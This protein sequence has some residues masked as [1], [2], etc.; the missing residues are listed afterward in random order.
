MA[1]GV[2]P[3]AADD[4]PHLRHART[5]QGLGGLVARQRLLVVEQTPQF[6]SMGRSFLQCFVHIPIKCSHS[7]DGGELFYI[8]TTTVMGLNERG[9]SLL[10]ECRGRLGLE[11]GLHGASFIHVG[12]RIGI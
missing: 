10:W 3:S 2:V 6:K 4:D 1:P 7:C 5:A 11:G 9:S 8:C 12:M